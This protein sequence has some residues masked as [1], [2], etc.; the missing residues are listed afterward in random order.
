MYPVTPDRDRLTHYQRPDGR[1]YRAKTPPAAHLI[2][3]DGDVSHV[4]VIRCD[5]YSYA[6][7]LAQYT[8]EFYDSGCEAVSPQF[9][10][11]REAIRN[12]ERYW[13][14]DEVKGACGYMFAVKEK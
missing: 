6:R 1:F 10:W 8:L 9:G 14:Y 2:N 4:L 5:D 3:I 12:N 7:N 11:W 13:E